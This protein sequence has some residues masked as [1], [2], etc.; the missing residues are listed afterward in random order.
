MSALSAIIIPK[1]VPF[2]LPPN[3]TI[4]FHRFRD[5]R[6][7][8]LA[9]VCKTWQTVINSFD[10]PKKV[11]PVFTVQKISSQPSSFYAKPLFQP[12]P[13]RFFS[14]KKDRYVSRG[15]N[16]REVNMSYKA[17]TCPADEYSAFI[18]KEDLSSHRF[19]STHGL[20]GCIGVITYDK[21][22]VSL[23]H[24]TYGVNWDIYKTWL[25]K[26]QLL[27]EKTRVALV[28]GLSDFHGSLEMV[29]ELEKLFAKHKMTIV[30]KDLYG[31]YH[32]SLSVS[33]GGE[34]TVQK[35]EFF[36]Y[37]SERM[38]LQPHWSISKV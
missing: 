15:E 35:W 5:K 1:H 16:A 17:E 28:G 26:N 12:T 25:S 24:L 14:V 20:S 13:H 37:F 6:E 21:N 38:V 3:A 36:G 9:C 27:T 8:S 23:S 7:Q 11:F 2:E 30:I 19:L 33:S 10:K 29:T 32:R 4:L 22:R 31:S 34:L 18:A